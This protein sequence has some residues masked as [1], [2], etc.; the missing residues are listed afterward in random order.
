VRGRAGREF[1]RDR[2]SARAQVQ[3]V[4]RLI[5]AAAA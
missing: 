3:A 2:F 4:Q 1:V 5:D